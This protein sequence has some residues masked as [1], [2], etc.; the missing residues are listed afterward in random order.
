[1]LTVHN[2]GLYFEFYLDG[3]KID[4]KLDP[5]LTSYFNNLSHVTLNLTLKEEDINYIPFKREIVEIQ[6]EE[7]IMEAL[8]DK[9][10]CPVSC[11]TCKWGKGDYCFF[12]GYCTDT[13][14][15]WEPKD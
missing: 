7:E 11:E 15:P 5:A 10:I 14:S 3:N 9:D 6:S 4:S 8:M 13:D 2:K 12:D 1:M